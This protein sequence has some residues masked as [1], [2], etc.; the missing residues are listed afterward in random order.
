[1]ELQTHKKKPSWHLLWVVS[2][3]S[4]GG[5][6]LDMQHFKD[7]CADP[8]GITCFPT[9]IGPGWQGGRIPPEIPLQE[10][11]FVV[12]CPFSCPWNGLFVLPEV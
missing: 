11:F 12:L 6:N 3:P 4:L 8:I 5:R 7:K 2:H 10:S 9:E 1:M